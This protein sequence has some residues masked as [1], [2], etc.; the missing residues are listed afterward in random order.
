MSIGRSLKSDL[1]YAKNLVGAGLTGITSAPRN[2]DAR[3]FVP[4]LARMVWAP[5]LVGAAAGILRAC[6]SKNKSGQNTL[7]NALVGS[8]LGFSG[9]V[10]WASKD[11]TGAAA[12]N[13]MQNVNSVRDARWLEKNPIAYA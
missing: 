1:S 4:A 13:A 6:L 11:Y 9:A 2:P 5:T 7:L 8:A 10:V 3:P 12:R